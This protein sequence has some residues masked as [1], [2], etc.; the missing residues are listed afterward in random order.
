[1]I[2]SGIFIYWANPI[3]TEFI[4]GDWYARLNLDHRLA[5]GMQLHFLFMWLFA[6]NGT[7]YV[8]YLVVSGEWRE[9]APRLSSFREAIQVTLHDLGLA[10]KLP[11]QGKFN[12]AQRFAY[13]TVVILGSAQILTG[14][15]IYKPVQL[16]ALT[17]AL[18]GYESARWIHFLI[19][20]AIV[21]FFFVHV[22]QV[23]KAGWNGF[24]AM[25]TGVERVQVPAQTPEVKNGD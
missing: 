12:A 7:L 13:S 22:M 6:L 15:A 14:L 17:H 11:P 10:K 4:P 2:V 9:L 20:V 8:I 3:Y 5:F 16:Q 18:G 19:T 25:L 23:I 21:A 24:Q 1:M